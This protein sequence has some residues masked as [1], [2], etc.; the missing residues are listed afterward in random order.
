MIDAAVQKR[1]L[2]QSIKD[3]MDCLA[4]RD[5]ILAWGR[6]IEHIKSQIAFHENLQEASTCRENVDCMLIAFH[7]ILSCA[8]RLITADILED[9]DNERQGL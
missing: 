3:Q 9:H 2:Y 8:D 4:Q 1:E 5:A 7:D 6:L